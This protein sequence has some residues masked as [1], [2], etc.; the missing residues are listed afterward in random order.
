MESMQSVKIGDLVRLEDG[1]GSAAARRQ[2]YRVTEKKQVNLVIAPT[3]GGKSVLVKPALVIK[4]DSETAP[5]VTTIEIQDPV[6]VGQVVRL[7][8]R[9]GLWVVIGSTTDYYKIA[10]LGGDNDRYL[11]RVTR[12]LLTPV[13]LE[14]LQLGIE[15]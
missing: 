11:T 2:T 4:V 6:V 5:A 10:R 14:E 1:V 15:A 3:M 7:A 8:G 12:R 13:S 9:D